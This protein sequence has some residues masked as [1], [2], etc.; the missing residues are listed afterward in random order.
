MTPK[1]KPL[2][3]PSLINVLGSAEL[4]KNKLINKGVQT[5]YNDLHTY[6]FITKI[7][8]STSLNSKP[9]LRLDIFSIL[10]YIILLWYITLSALQIYH[11]ATRK[12]H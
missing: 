6:F 9:L 8:G 3:R 11:L 7:Q 10:E 1:Q 4:F 12:L 2:Q 5:P